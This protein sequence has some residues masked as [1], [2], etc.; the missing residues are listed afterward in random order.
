MA[1]MTY[2]CNICIIICA[3]RVTPG[4][5]MMEIKGSRVIIPANFAKLFL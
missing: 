1:N 5:D 2:N 3:S 4:Y